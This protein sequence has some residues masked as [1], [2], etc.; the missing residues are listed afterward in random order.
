M[1]LLSI[2]E[3]NQF[4]TH[5]DPSGF[6]DLGHRSANHLSTAGDEHDFIGIGD[7]ESPHDESGFIAGL[8]GDDSLAATR[9]G[10]IILK[11]SALAD[12]VLSGNEESIAWANEA[13]RDNFIPLVGTDTPDANGSAALIAKFF[14]AKADAHALFGDHHNLVMTIG[15]RGGDKNISFFDIDGDDASL[16]DIGKVSEVGLFHNATTGGEENVFLTIP[17]G[18]NAGRTSRRGGLNTERGGHLL[19]GLEIEDIGD[20]ASLGRA[21]HFGDLMHAL[22]I[23]ATGLGKE[24]KVVMRTGGEEMFDEVTFIGLVLGLARGHADDPLASTALGAIGA[25]GGA[26]D[27]ALVGDGDDAAFVGNEILDGDLALFG[28][29]LG[30]TRAGV[31]VADHLEFALDDRQDTLLGAEDVE[32]IS[33][34]L[35][36]LLI[37]SSDLVALESG[38]LIEAEFEDGIGLLL[39]EAIGTVLTQAGFTAEQDTEFSNLILGKFE[40]K[41][42]A[43]SLVTVLRIADDTDELIHI[44]QSDE[45]AFEL[46]SACLGLAKE[47]AGTAQD[48]LAAMFDEAGDGLLEGEK[49]GTPSVDGEHGDGEG[50]FKRRVLV[51]IIDDHLGNG[52]A[53]Q[54]DHH[55]SILIGLVADGADVG[56]DFFIHQSGDTLHK[57]GTVDIV[58]NLSDDDLFASTL[59]LLHSGT[60]THLHRTAPGFEILTDASDTAELAAGR[61][62]GPF[63]VHHQLIERDVGVINLG[64]DRVD[65]LTEIVRRNIGRHTDGNTGAT[66]DEEIWNRCREDG[67]FLTGVIVVGNEVD[68]VV[69]HV[70]HEDGAERTESGF[71]ISHRGRRITFHR[72]EVSLALDQGLAHCPS[73]SHVNECRIDRLVT[74]RVIV[75]HRF[76]DDLGAFEMLASRHDSQLAHRKENAALRGLQTVAGIGKGSGNDDRHRVIEE[77]SGDLFGDIDG[78]DFFV[79]IIQGIGLLG[80]LGVDR[81]HDRGGRTKLES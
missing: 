31:L 48:D 5:R 24:D 3:I 52:I 62:I 77:G 56:D 75:T 59:D 6:T 73:L 72:T 61:E 17:G 10:S 34:G 23:A 35:E 51:E 15:Q 68:R 79:L 16:T 1:Q 70:L 54:L 2:W 74:M 22:D 43:T 20:G 14:F 64:T 57:R 44:G 60:T 80:R 55:A 71:G 33:D 67:W 12:T 8:H 78:F 41:Q 9:L 7:G 26:F 65:G 69:I 19:A 38:E 37:L 40:G 39:T 18:V 45:I 49:L 63:D 53:L 47:E 21:A 42:A 13:D 25:H 58:R 28:N 50:G 29:E 32:Q 11:G 4:H 30:E 46:F 66:V 76:T 27:E 81:P 36:K